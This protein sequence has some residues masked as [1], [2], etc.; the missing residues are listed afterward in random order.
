MKT[1]VSFLFVMSAALPAAE[2]TN[3][4]TVPSQATLTGAAATQQFLAVATYADGTERDI[5]AEAEWR[6][7]QPQAARFV[8][9]ARIGP[10]KNGTLSVTATIG[11]RTATSSVRIADA[12][13][14]ETHRVHRRYYRG[15]LPSVAA[16]AHRATEA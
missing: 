9:T 16:T 13:R 3:L 10:L 12:E 11:G 15:C 4:R 7:S 6:V 14:R 8:S 1:L 5:T 2:M